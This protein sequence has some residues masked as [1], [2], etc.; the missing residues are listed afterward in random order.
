MDH[1]WT[2]I[3]PGHLDS[4]RIVRRWIEAILD[5]TPVDACGTD[6]AIYAASELTTNALVHTASGQPGGTVGLQLLLGTS[7]LRVEV[8][9]EGGPGQPI[10]RTPSP[11]A[12]HG[13]GLW[14]V[15]LQCEHLS[16]HG[17][18]HGHTVCADLQW[19]Q[20]KPGEVAADLPPPLQTQSTAH[21]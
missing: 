2:H 19:R 21:T 9:D 1:I 7:R 14:L 17:D 16:C 15:K 5:H 3:L 11:E 10:I 4:V 12:E 13:R 20:P 18:K 8:T 6:R